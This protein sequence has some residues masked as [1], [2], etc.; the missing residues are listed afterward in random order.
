MTHWYTADTHFNHAAIIRHC[1]RPY[2]DSAEMDQA[3]LRNLEARVQPGDDL[4]IIGDFGFGFDARPDYLQHCFDRVP[5]RKHLIVGNHDTSGICGLGWTSV[6]DL[7]EVKDGGMAF[8]LC[9]YPMITWNGAR[10]GAIQLFGHVHKHWQGS[11]NSVNVGVDVWNYSPVQRAD[12][13]GRAERLPVNKHWQD[14]EPR[15]SRGGK[16]LTDDR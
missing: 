1:S 15:G 9:H 11:T 5:G 7:T 13:Q 12:I 8:V 2:R 16:N 4:W 14:V 10:R 3:I 6:R